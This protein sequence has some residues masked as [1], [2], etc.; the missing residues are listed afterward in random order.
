[1]R[2]ICKIGSAY[3]CNNRNREVNNKWKANL[4][5][6]CHCVL[7]DC[8]CVCAYIWM[9]NNELNTLKNI[10]FQSFF[11]MNFN[12]LFVTHFVIISLHDSGK[13]ALILMQ[14]QVNLKR[15]SGI[16]GFD[17]RGEGRAPPPLF[18][19]IFWIWHRF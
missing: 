19:S 17:A 15:L 6:T 14:A 3:R 2:I 13:Q 7:Y 12:F 18:T 1:M 16:A 8:V 9:Q 5:T 4:C 10:V 11:C